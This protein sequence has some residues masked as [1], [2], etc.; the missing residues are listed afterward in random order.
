MKSVIWVFGHT[1]NQDGHFLWQR[2]GQEVLSSI[3]TPG[4][5]HQQLQQTPGHHQEAGG[6][7]V[8]TH[9]EVVGGVQPRCK[10]TENSCCNE[11][12]KILTD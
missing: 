11:N 10:G 7:V 5:K 2:P 8:F 1:L 3:E 9:Q 12:G 4:G 6:Q